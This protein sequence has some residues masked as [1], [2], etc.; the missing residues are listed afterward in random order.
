[1]FILESIRQ[2]LE[3]ESV[4]GNPLILELSLGICLSRLALGDYYYTIAEMAGVCEATVCT[5]V[6][7]VRDS[8]VKNLWNSTVS[9]IFPK[10][11][12]EFR[13]A[14]ITL[15]EHWQLPCWFG[16]IDGATVP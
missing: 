14:M 13:E 7:K 6:I 5:I 4:G 2:G 8:I 9:G 12:D 15:K 1:M 10:T 11:E 3:P 16:A